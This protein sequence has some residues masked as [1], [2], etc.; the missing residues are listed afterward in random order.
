M[1]NID[2]SKTSWDLSPL[3]ASEDDPKIQTYREQISK[4][5][6]AFADKWRQRRDYLKE[7]AALKE[8]LDEL[9][10]WERMPGLANCSIFIL[11]FG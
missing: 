3:L 2:T 5:A 10:A 6:D 4:S 7:P 8:A 11:T 9:E 1:A